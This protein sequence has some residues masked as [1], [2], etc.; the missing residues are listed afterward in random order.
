MTIFSTQ[1][2]PRG[3]DVNAI[4]KKF[5]S[6]LYDTP[7][8]LELFPKD[9]ILIANKRNQNL[10]ELLLRADPYNVKDNLIVPVGKGY[11]KCDEKCN[12]CDNFVEESTRLKCNATNR[13]YY[14]RNNL[15]CDSINVIYVATCGNCGKQG[16]GS[17]VKWKPRLSNKSHIKKKIRSCCIVNHFID[18]CVDEVNPCRF[19]KFILVDNVNNTSN[20]SPKEIDSLLLEKEIFWIGTLIS[21]HKG[22]NGS[23]DWSRNKRCEKVKAN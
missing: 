7:S 10:K 1:F 20:L 11:K 15:L 18:E 16:V 5:A 23:H 12:S 22:L 6:M 9:S 14:I 3:P 17:T 19:L 21:Q 8:C 2:N 13:I 4:V